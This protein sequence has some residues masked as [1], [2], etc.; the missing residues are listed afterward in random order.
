MRKSGTFVPKQDAVNGSM[1]ED[2]EARRI[3]ILEKIGGGVAVAGGVEDGAADL[4]TGNMVV[5]EPIVRRDPSLQQ[6]ISDGRLPL[7]HRRLKRH[8]FLHPLVRLVH[9]PPVPPHIA[10]VIR[11]RARVEPRV[12]ATPAAQN[13]CARVYDAVLGDE[14][15]RRRGRREVGEGG[16]ERR[17]VGDV[18]IA[19]GRTSPFK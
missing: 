9:Q 7:P 10:H 19:V 3:S 1:Q 8:L 2:S 14:T 12:K 5:R 16:A 15:L 17:Q 13:A 18:G 11:R 4:S 6:S